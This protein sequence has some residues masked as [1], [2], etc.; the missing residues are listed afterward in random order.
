MGIGRRADHDQGCRQNR[1]DAGAYRDGGARFRLSGTGYAVAAFQMHAGI[2]DR[3]HCRLDPLPKA[4]IRSFWDLPAVL[5]SEMKAR[6]F[7]PMAMLRSGRCPCTTVVRGT[8][9]VSMTEP[10]QTGSSILQSPFRRKMMALQE[11]LVGYRLAPI[12]NVESKMLNLAD[13]RVRF[14]LS[15]H[16]NLAKIRNGRLVVMSRFGLWH[17]RTDDNMNYVGC[18]NISYRILLALKV[19]DPPEQ[20]HVEGC[21]HDRRKCDSR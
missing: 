5:H 10:P 21:R 8:S 12:P 6:D 14:N 18:R 4:R 7:T 20:P 15:P 16:T 13:L 17:V 19:P 9:T 2:R 3:S 11:E 1:H